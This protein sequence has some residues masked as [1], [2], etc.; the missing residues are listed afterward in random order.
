MPHED[1]LIEYLSKEIEIQSS[2]IMTFRT[3]A[4][5]PVFLGP[6]VLLGSAFASKGLPN[7]ITLNRWTYF[8][9]A[10]LALS[11]LAMGISAAGIESQIWDQCNRWREL[12]ASVAS[13]NPVKITKKD[14]KFENK[15]NRGYLVVYLAMLGAFVF[16]LLI[17]LRLQFPPPPK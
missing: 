4:N 6:F 14:L 7:G 1:K 10:G 12:I 9:F 17:V 5:L 2:N 8:Y 3:R 16:A 13:Q 11:Y 15:L